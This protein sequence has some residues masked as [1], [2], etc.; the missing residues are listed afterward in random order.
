MD[1]FLKWVELIFNYE[2]PEYYLR[3]LREYSYDDI[4][5]KYFDYK[6]ISSMSPYQISCFL[7]YDSKDEKDSI[8]LNYEN[9]VLNDIISPDFLPIAKGNDGNYVCIGME[10]GIYARIYFIKRYRF[11][12]YPIRIADSFFEWLNKLYVHE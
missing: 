12:L 4:T 7:S 2:L 9:A 8:I 10:N 6:D 5:G 3:Y 11:G 1:E